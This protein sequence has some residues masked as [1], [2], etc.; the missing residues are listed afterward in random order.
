MNIPELL[1]ALHINTLHSLKKIAIKN[2]LSIQQILCIYSIPQEGI[3]QTRLADSLSI[4]VSTL[5]RNLKK[6]EIQDIIIKH[7]VKSDDRFLNI[8]L[9]NYGMGLFKSILLDLTHYTKNLHLDTELHNTQE[10]ID[11]LLKLNWQI[12]RYK[13]QDV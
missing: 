7:P 11:S 4:D 13:T 1:I 5:S 9:T 8:C 6:L 3:T 12:L 10:I 2:K